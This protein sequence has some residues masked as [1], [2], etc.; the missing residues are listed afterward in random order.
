MQ[1]LAYAY[2]QLSAMLIIRQWRRRQR[3]TN[4]LERLNRGLAPNEDILLSNIYVTDLERLNV[5]VAENNF[6][7]IVSF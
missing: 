1:N 5:N 7:T 4:Y 6:S 3:H 2:P